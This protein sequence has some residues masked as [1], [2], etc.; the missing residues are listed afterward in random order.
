[1]VRQFRELVLHSFGLQID[2]ANHTFDSRRIIGEREQP[3]RFSDCLARLHGDTA[4]KA[5]LGQQGF[6]VF[7]QPIAMQ[8]RA[9]GNPRILL[10][11]V[12]PEM[13]MRINFHNTLVS[14]RAAVPDWS[15]PSET[16]QPPSTANTW[17]VT[18]FESSDRK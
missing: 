9:F 11:V 7:G 3:V 12:T 5:C 6:D 13:L 1:S 18:N 8:W 10:F 4:V 14:F 17:P 2:P 15:C 16:H